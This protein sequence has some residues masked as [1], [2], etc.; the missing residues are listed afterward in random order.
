MGSGKSLAGEGPKGTFQGKGES[1]NNMSVCKA[2]RAVLVD[3]GF[4]RHASQVALPGGLRETR[5]P[6]R[7]GELVV[8]AW[9][10]Q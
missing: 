9:L 10:C 7:P 4:G 1:I 2:A 3:I 5:R 8:A 6:A